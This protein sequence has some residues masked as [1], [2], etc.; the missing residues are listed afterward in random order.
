MKKFSAITS[1][2]TKLAGIGPVCVALVGTGMLGASLPAHSEFKVSGHAAYNA[3]D[4][5]SE[6]DLV[7]QRNGFS[8]SRFRLIYAHEL[9]SGMKIEVAQEFG[10]AEGE[11]SLD[12]RRQEVIFKDSWGGVRFG[13]GNDAGDGNLNGDLSGTSI[14]QPMA[15]NAAAYGY[16]SNYID[17]VRGFVK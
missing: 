12:S 4:R 2:T 7:F 5:D 14:I 10:I 13:Q 1:T 17:A 9:E 16:S 15:S 11:G 8:E 6:E 3:V